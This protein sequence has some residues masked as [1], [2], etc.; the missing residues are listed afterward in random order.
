M[1]IF[2]TG[3]NGF[4]G[5][6][7]IKQLDLLG[8]DAWAV[9]RKKTT[10]KKEVEID[11]ETCSEVDL[12][13]KIRDADCIIH[14][15]A[16]ANFTNHFDELVYQVNCLSNI[17]LVNFCKK[18]SVYLIFASNALISGL[19][20]KFISEKTNDNPE[21]PYNISK[22]ISEKYITKNLTNYSILRIGG[23]YGLD[24]PRHLFLNKSITDAIKLSDK[25]FINN[26]GEGKRNYIYV[27]DLCSWI[28]FIMKNKIKGKHLIAGPETLTIKEI[29]ELIINVFL[30]GNGEINFNKINIGEDQVIDCKFPDIK[31][32]NYK[33]A[34]NQIKIKAKLA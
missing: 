8:F 24:G 7:L 18:N 2:V 26:N 30:D 32:N 13:S 23:I 11:F 5:K 21:I 25:F 12:S 9:V 3:A 27:E 15:A 20:T 19:N 34:F 14:L 17:M 10:R 16:N 6:Y 22:Y 1:K 28:I 29:Y 33:S 4:V 31:L